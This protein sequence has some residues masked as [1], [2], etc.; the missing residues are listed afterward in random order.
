M[1]L[2]KRD[3]FYKLGYNENHIP[4][5]NKI[6]NRKKRLAAW[7]DPELNWPP[8]LPR[9]TM[10]K[11]K[12]LLNQLDSAEKKNI[13]EKRDFEIPDYRTGDVVRIK[14]YHSMSELKENELSGVVISK[15]MPSNIRATCKINFSIDT[16]NT[17]Y[18]AKLYSPLITNFEILKYGSNRLRRRLN[19]IP[20]LDF[21][22]GRL[23][24]PVTK[25]R[26]YKPRVAKEKVVQQ[27]SSKHHGKGKV[28][29]GSYKM[30]S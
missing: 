18:G 27:V 19:Y 21:P 26:G 10:H 25:G 16:V 24:E 23:Q 1:M 11:G 17:V 3:T 13:I 9:P 22:A 20:L 2:K 6:K 14:M 15:S 28:K 29:K 5:Q 4:A 8:R 12:T 7:D 30:D